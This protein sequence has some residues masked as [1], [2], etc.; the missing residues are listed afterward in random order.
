MLNLTTE[1]QIELA[2]DINVTKEELMELANS[3]EW[4]VRMLVARNVRT[5]I[6]TLLI[7]DRDKNDY[8]R[9]EA[10]TTIKVLN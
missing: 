10:N 4:M 8:V 7:L 2:R 5:P 9:K 3:D 6:Q 1:Q